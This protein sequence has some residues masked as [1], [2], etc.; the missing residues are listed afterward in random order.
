MFNDSTKDA[1]MRYMGAASGQIMSAGASAI[2]AVMQ[3]SEK[4]ENRFVLIKECLN[5]GMSPDEI[6]TM[7]ELSES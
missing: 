6:A 3:S 5:A 1:A 2:S 4:F 7:I